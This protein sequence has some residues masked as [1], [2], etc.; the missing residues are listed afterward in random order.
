[1]IIEYT[2]VRPCQTDV[3]CSVVLARRL[4]HI[5]DVTI[6]AST[7]RFSSTLDT[8]FYYSKVSWSRHATWESAGLNWNCSDTY[9]VNA[10]WPQ[11]NFAFNMLL[12]ASNTLFKL[13]ARPRAV[14]SPVRVRSQSGTWDETSTHENICPNPRPT[15]TQTANRALAT[16]KA[17]YFS[18][19]HI[20][21]L[22]ECVSSF[23]IRVFRRERSG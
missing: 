23:F 14:T 4:D 19:V 16:K 21:R 1:M 20:P 17:H 3:C 9:G 18:T 13:G 5:R 15:P 11:S 6:L 22:R 8:V 10:G 12:T 7:V 2:G